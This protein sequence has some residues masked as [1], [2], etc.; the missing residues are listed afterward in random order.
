MP[1]TDS[2]DTGGFAQSETTLMGQ[3][4][5]ELCDRLE[6]GAGAK[7][8]VTNRIAWAVIQAVQE[9]ET[10]LEGICDEALRKLG[11]KKPF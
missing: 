4:Y 7:D 5:D 3:A 8:Y 6:V 2:F 9:G 11:I 10:T 1:R